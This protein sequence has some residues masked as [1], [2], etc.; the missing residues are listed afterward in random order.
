MALRFF[1]MNKRTYI[2]AT[3]DAAKDGE[4]ERSLGV[5]CSLSCRE[6]EQG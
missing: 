3:R 2:E 4:E 5:M 1:Q 6:F